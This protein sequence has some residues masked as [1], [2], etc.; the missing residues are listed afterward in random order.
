MAGI[1][2]N[3]WPIGAAVAKRRSI[4]QRHGQG[5]ISDQA[6]NTAPTGIR[7][8]YTSSIPKSEQKVN[9]IKFKSQNM[10]T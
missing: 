6:P 9:L 5:F 7:S 4:R 3:K 1:S 2:S 10:T 8:K